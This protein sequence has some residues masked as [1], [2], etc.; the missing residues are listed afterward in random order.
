MARFND[1]TR[2]NYRHGYRAGYIGNTP[3]EATSAAERAL[4]GNPNKHLREVSRP[5]PLPNGQW[6]VLIT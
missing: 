6:R 1:S 5:E 3:E 2:G 4:A